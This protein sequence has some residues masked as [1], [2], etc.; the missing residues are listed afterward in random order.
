MIRRPPRSTLDRS[1]AASD[2]YKRQGSQ[3][4][5]ASPRLL[6]KFNI[7]CEQ[8]PKIDNPIKTFI[9]EQVRS[10]YLANLDLNCCCDS[11]ISTPV[12][13]NPSLDVGFTVNGLA[14]AICRILSKYKVA[15]NSFVNNIDLLLGTD[16]L[17]HM[18]HF[19]MVEC[20]EGSAI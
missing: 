20:L 9:G 12:L 5:Y 16:T 14:S 19:Q 17:C 3:R 10:S 11:F 8:L 18:K 1:S 6:N 2:V 15:D 13:V 7:N 4:T